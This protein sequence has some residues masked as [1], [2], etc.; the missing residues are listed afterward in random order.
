MTR[1]PTLVRALIG[2]A[3][4]ATPTAL[5]PAALAQAPTPN[6]TPNAA[7]ELSSASVQVVSVP[8]DARYYSTLI[9]FASRPAVL[10]PDGA[11]AW[12]YSR[13]RS[14]DDGRALGTIALPAPQLGQDLLPLRAVFGSVAGTTG[15]RTGPADGDERWRYGATLPTDAVAWRGANWILD[16]LAT[17]RPT[18][19]ALVSVRDGVGGRVE[20]RYSRDFT[21]D[22]VIPTDRGLRAIGQWS[23]KVGKGRKLVPAV[24]APGSA[25]PVRIKVLDSITSAA[26]V[27]GGGLLVTGFGTVSALPD[28]VVLIDARGRARRVA[29]RRSPVAAFA[30]G[31]SGIVPIGRNVLLAESSA[32][33]NFSSRTIDKSALVVRGAD[34]KVKLRRLV[35]E[36]DYPGASGCKV[37]GVV[38]EVVGVRSGPD[39]LPIAA[40]VCGVNQPTAWGGVQFSWLQATMVGLNADLTV[41]WW[42]RAPEVNF[43]DWYVPQICGTVT[44][45]GSGRLAIVR[46]GRTYGSPIEPIR[47][48]TFAV[49]TEGGAVPPAGRLAR[50]ARVGK[51]S[52]RA[53][54]VCRGAVGTV[55]S[56]TARVTANGQP[57]GSA[58]YV[59]PA[60]PGALQ[61]ELDRQIETTVPLP[62]RYSVTLTPRG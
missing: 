23:V 52:V 4:I 27:P 3:L 49:P 41:R 61:G 24:T 20:Q 47:L 60:R 6:P 45:I 44:T 29:D 57:L 53:R 55:C 28:P 37:A 56:G 54:I 51:Q 31:R 19:V 48:T 42:R 22:R 15:L 25:R 13:Q 16:R 9:D 43:Q 35:A 26:A 38:H 40:I 46:C 1:L 18:R 14:A 50:S 32:E 36:L 7:P 11:L 17:P 21:P 58:D 5:A 8:D 12:F 33:D 30:T 39:G 62:K 59:V 2:G 34:G 10:A